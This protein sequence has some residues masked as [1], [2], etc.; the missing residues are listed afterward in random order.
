MFAFFVGLKTEN[1][2][3]IVLYIKT[4]QKIN[5]QGSKRAMPVAN[6]KRQ[7]ETH[8]QANYVHQKKY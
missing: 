3:L 6:W 1:T 8:Q 5:E 2:I 4:A 7:A